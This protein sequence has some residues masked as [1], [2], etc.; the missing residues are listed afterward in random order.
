MSFDLILWLERNRLHLIH[1]IGLNTK[2]LIDPLEDNE[3]ALRFTHMLGT[4]NKPRFFGSSVQQTKVIV[5]D[6][7]NL[8]LGA[9]DK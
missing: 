9:I 4:R 6:R 2:E 3:K 8:I 1:R 5:I 7:E